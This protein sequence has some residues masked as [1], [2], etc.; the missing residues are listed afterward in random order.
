MT[1]VELE[2]ERKLIVALDVPD[3]GE[4]HELWQRLG[5]RHAIAKIGLELL[6]SGGAGLVRKLAGEGIAVFVDAKLLDISITVERA[7]ARA[8]A[9][10]AAFL[11]VHAQDRLTVEAAV[12]GRAGSALKL[13]GV[14][15]L[16]STPPESLG[17]QGISLPAQELVLRRAG[18]AADAGFEGVVSSPLEA[19]A[20]K[21]AF[22]SQLA[23]VCP[24]IRPRAVSTHDQARSTTPAEAIRAGADYIV[25]GRPVTKASDPA[26]AARAIVAEMAEAL[27][28]K[29]S[30]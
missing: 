29:Q 5:L 22:G 13:L 28:C 14:T 3:T 6:F 26:A 2:A 18:F 10:G 20:L 4:A 17:E 19:Q 9:L 24:G 7:T 16:T 23:V 27:S 21:Q 25:V 8:A 1:P 15:L 11:T 12:R 30:R